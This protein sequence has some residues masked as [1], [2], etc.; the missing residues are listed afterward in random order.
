M[1]TETQTTDAQTDENGTVTETATKETSDAKATSPQFEEKDGKFFIEGKR[2]YSRDDT[3]KIAANAKNEAVN[4]LLADLD[5]DSLDQVKEV[6]GTLKSSVKS[7]DGTTLDVQALQNAVAKREATVEELQAEVSSLKTNLM[8]KDHIGNLNGAMPDN[9]TQDQKS[10]VV[11]LMKARD[12][13]AIEGDSFQ[14]RNGD[15]F[16]TVDGEKPDY[17]AAVELIGKTLG[18]N[19]AKKG[20][21]VVN[22]EQSPGDSSSKVK[23]LDEGRLQTDKEYH[24]AYMRIR[25]YQPNVSRGSITNNMVQKQMDKMRQARGQA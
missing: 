18:L 17:N 22:A 11:D 19:S 10:A 25:Q 7:D 2:V 16:L 3:N 12:M 9:W 14:L 13:F 6:I 8:L 24:N 1:S 21:N 5:L 23:V 15:D 4:A 20:V